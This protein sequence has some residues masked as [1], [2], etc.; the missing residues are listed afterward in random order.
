M[1]SG[2]QDDPG[3]ERLSFRGGL[4]IIAAMNSEPWQLRLVKRSLKKK[5]K[6]R[7]LDRF[8]PRRDSRV[9][10]DLGCAQGILSYFVRRKGGFWVSADEDLVN[11]RSARDVLES[12]LV[13]LSGTAL[14]FPDGAFDLVVGLDYLEHVE[15]DDRVLEEISRVLRGGGEVVLVTPQT[16]PFFLLHKLRA[17]LGLKLEHFGHKR[18]GYSLADL[19]A[20]L[21]RASL[22]LTESADYSRFFSEFFELVLNFVY[23]KL[24][25]SAASDKRRDG[26]IR[27]STGDE[28]SAQSGLFGAYCLVYPIVWLLSQMDRLLVFEKGYSVMVRARKQT[29]SV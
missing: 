8:V 12:G 15:D 14:P 9:A 6:L 20:K 13:A 2:E 7:L 25:A 10:L 1:D 24:L 4:N 23:V 16:G 21:S 19:E 29:P 5:I 28:F 27:P 22:R 18:E 17:V 26:H 11:L 3:G